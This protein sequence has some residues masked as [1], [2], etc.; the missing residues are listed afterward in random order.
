VNTPE[1]LPVVVTGEDLL[2]K[3]MEIRDIFP[4]DSRLVQAF[5]A[6]HQATT[7]KSCH[8]CARGHNAR[9]LEG[10]LGHDILY[11][12]HRKLL[13]AI[14]ALYP[15]STSINAPTP[16]RWVDLIENKA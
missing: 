13:P 12:G 4:P 14:Q 1:L 2:E 3:E 6:F 8:G 7:V 11:G 5:N 15:G 9:K 16:K 10:A